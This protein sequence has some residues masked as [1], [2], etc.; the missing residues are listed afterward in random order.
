MDSSIFF[1]FEFLAP[2]HFLVGTK[3]KEKLSIKT[4]YEPFQLSV[5]WNDPIGAKQNKKPGP[6]LYSVPH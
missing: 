4:I 1:S 3:T 6:E 5:L 2:A